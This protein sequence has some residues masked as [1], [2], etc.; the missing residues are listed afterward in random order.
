MCQT[1]LTEFLAELTEF[2]AELSEFSLVK[3]YSLET[4]FRPFPTVE[5][6]TVELQMSKRRRYAY[7]VNGGFPY[8][9]SSAKTYSFGEHFSIAAAKTQCQGCNFRLQNPSFG[10][11]KPCFGLKKSQFLA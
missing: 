8:P 4:V 7:P 10:V 11:Q 3:Q 5:V 2:A 1:E 9:A 6:A